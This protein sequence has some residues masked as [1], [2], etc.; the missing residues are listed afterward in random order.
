MRADICDSDDEAAVSRFKSTLK[1][2]GAKSLGK[3]WA[4]GVDV[5]DLQIGDETLR[6]FSDAW[7]VDIEGTDQLVRQVLRVFNEVGSKS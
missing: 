2:M 1:K 7:S 6:V 5:L 3:T 4:I